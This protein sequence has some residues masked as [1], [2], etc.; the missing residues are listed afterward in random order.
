MAVIEVK[1]GVYSV[2]AVDWDRTLFDELIPLPDGTSYNAFLIKGEEKVAL[3]DTVDPSTEEEL[4]SNLEK[5]GV[6]RIDYIVSN[7]AEQD[8]SGSIP[9]VLARFP[10][11]KVVTNRKCADFLKSLLPLQGEAFLI[12]KE[13]DRIDLGGRHLSFIMTPWTHW[14]E[15]MCTYL[16]EDK[17]L[18][19]CDLFGSHLASNLLYG[20]SKEKVYEAAKRYYAEIMMPFRTSIKKHIEKL[21]SLEI[22]IIAP[23]HGPLYSD[24]SFI[25]NAYRDWTGERV[26]NQVVLPF[27]SMHGSTRAM[28][29][30][31][32]EL[33]TERGIEVLPF[34]LVVADVGEL[35]MAL[36]DAATLVLASPTMLAGAHPLAFYATYLVSILRP[37]LRFA[38]LIGSYGWG[39]RMEQQI[40]DVLSSLKAEWLKT[41]I[42]KGFPEEDGFRQL[43]E[44]ADLI[45]EAHKREGLL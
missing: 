40:K 2:G 3:I 13:G 14:P 20:P 22:E 6:K 36:V 32:I 7:H 39:G 42:V 5:A 12:I 43:E 41:V 45:K 16:E 9:A 26:K 15:T 28:V 8:H 30:Y 35:A 4:L 31:L 24:P 25:L 27:V 33:L 37:K 29:D 10:E 17:I 34:N 19:T 1:P 44:L 23:S 21:S 38:A 18:F 11:A